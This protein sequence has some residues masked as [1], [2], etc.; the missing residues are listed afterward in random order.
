MIVNSTELQLARRFCNGM[1]DVS[2][3]DALE[4]WRSACRQADR[5][6]L[7]GELLL[8][9]EPEGNDEE[10]DFEPPTCYVPGY[11]WMVI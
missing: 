6:P 2:D 10:P 7:T 3:A 9:E 4:Y 11:G 1:E 8:P 5:N